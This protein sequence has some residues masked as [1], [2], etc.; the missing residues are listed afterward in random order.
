MTD[1]LRA[2]QSRRRREDTVARLVPSPVSEEAVDDRPTTDRDDSLLL[3]FLCCHPSLSV[4]SQI[5]LTLR[6]VGGLTTSE[7]AH[8]FLV[9]E[10]TMA[11]RISRAKQR[12]VEAGGRFRMPSAD[13]Y[14]ERL[15]AVLHVLY[16]V[17]NE[18][19]TATSGSSLQRKELSGEAIR[20]T[21]MFQRMLPA[22]GEVTGLLALMLLTD[23]RGPARTHADGDLVPLSEQDRS[24]WDRGQI[25]EGRALVDEALSHGKPGSYQLQAAMAAVHAAAERAEDTDWQQILRL[26]ELLERI[27]DN[28]VVVLNHAVAAAMVNGPQAGLDM[29]S[30]LE[31]DS[32]M[33]R[34]HRLD[35]VRAH[36]LEM[37]GDEVAAIAFYRQAAGRT[38]SPPERRYLEGRAVSLESKEHKN[39][40]GRG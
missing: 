35:A 32:R 20:L 7:I 22:N 13:G 36:L 25:S 10:T 39:P 21:R 12:V 15:G 14:A 31:H 26:Y 19:Y 38:T 11:Q 40:S 29:L 30:D 17:F 28:P 3:L 24:L 16:L 37:V 27:E 6:V 9:P 2:E 34:T 23:A 33:S 8:A 18:G 5:A 1:M 4:A